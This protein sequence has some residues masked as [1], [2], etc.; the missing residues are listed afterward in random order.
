M[1]HDGLKIGLRYGLLAFF[2]SA[3]MAFP[4]HATL[5]D[6][7]FTSTVS[8]GSLDTGSGPADLTGAAVV[9]SGTT[10]SD[11]DANPGDPAIGAFTALTVFDFGALGSFTA[12]P[13]NTFYFQVSGSTT[14]FNSIG[15]F[16]NVPDFVSGFGT[17]IAPVASDANVAVALGDVTTLGGINNA[18]GSM[19]NSLGHTLTVNILGGTALTDIS[20]TAAAV[21]EPATLTLLG[22][23]LAWLGVTRRR[24]PS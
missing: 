10:V 7:T 17:S 14:S 21:P 23:G 2:L 19:S 9:I 22:L 8:S 18:T 20:V 11:V 5:L 1:T 3:S 4:A 15:M 12:D 13:G 16:Y 24:R 6:F